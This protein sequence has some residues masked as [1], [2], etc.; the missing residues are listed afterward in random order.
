[1]ADVL[2]FR[3]FRFDMN[4]YSHA[5]LARLLS[6]PYD[7]IEQDSQEDL[8]GDSFSLD[9][10]DA[11][12]RVRIA[13]TRH[14]PTA[15]VQENNYTQTRRR[16]MDWLAEGVLKIDDQPMLYIYHQTFFSPHGEKLTRQ[17][18]I[19]RVQLED[20]EN[21]VVLP[22]ERTLSAPKVDR[23]N[24][25][26][27]TEANLSQVFML[28]D[29]PEHC[30]NAMLEDVIQSSSPLLEITTE[31]GILHQLWGSSNEVLAGAVSDFFS[32][33]Q[34]L[35]ADGH[36]RYETALAYRDF[37]CEMDCPSSTD[38]DDEHNAPYNYIMTLLVNMHD[39]GLL[40]LPTHRVVHDVED[41]DAQELLG[42]LERSPFFEVTPLDVTGE[43]SVVDRGLEWLKACEQAGEERP[44]F[45]LCSR[46][47]D[48]PVLVSFTGS[49]SSAI[50]TNDTPEPVRALDVTILHEG[51]LDDIL[52]IDREA[53]AAK[54]NL[55]YK[56]HLEEALLE[57]EL[58]DTQLVI[59]MNA[60][61]VEQINRV[62][63][64]GGKMP[65]KSTYFYPKIL[66]GLMICPL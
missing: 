53:Q 20:Y 8:Q 18:M 66:S 35:I 51:I 56:K 25:M 58:P 38:G 32:S 22:H 37:R 47:F 11:L 52:G 34:L 23:L 48:V 61:P 29:D 16:I 46:Y 39:P 65:Q 44:S 36:H 2:P 12:A 15:H 59:L 41:F 5:Q 21:K 57:L 26:K 10:L 45:V 1:M 60:T 6:Y 7:G 64:S 43:M 50:F 30:I 63:Q 28:Y 4:R 33:R 14:Y 24:L 27:A 54:T 42:A 17:G 40:V 19:A 31:D 49:E 55:R 13:P 9:A 3:S 62:C